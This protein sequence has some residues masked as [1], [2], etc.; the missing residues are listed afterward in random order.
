MRADGALLMLKQYRHALRSS[1][2]ELPAGTLE[3]GEDPVVCAQRE[4]REETGFGA[5]SIESLGIIHPAPGFCNE[6]QHLFFAKDLYLDPAPQDEDEVIEVVPMELSEVEQ[7]I[8]VG[9]ITDAKTLAA[10]YRAKLKGLL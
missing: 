7:R 6:I 2:F 8:L 1:I 10:L 5:K 9:E 4:V 3:A